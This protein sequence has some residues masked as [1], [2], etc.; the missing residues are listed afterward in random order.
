MLYG[1]HMILEAESLSK[2]ALWE[3]M[4]LGLA[5]ALAQREAQGKQTGLISEIVGL[6]TFAYSQ[7]QQAKN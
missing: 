3:E 7:N 6:P 4:L 5:V 2:L 1:L